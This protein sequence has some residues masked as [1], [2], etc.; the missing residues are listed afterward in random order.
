[1]YGILLATGTTL[2]K[3]TSTTVQYD[4]SISTCGAPLGKFLE[5]SWIDSEGIGMIH[6]GH[7]VTLTRPLEVNE[8]PWQAAEDARRHFLGSPT[9]VP[10]L[11]L[12]VSIILTNRKAVDGWSVLVWI[13]DKNVRKRPRL[14]KCIVEN[15]RFTSPL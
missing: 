11:E 8:W 5:D 10:I 12:K 6:D 15:A 7:S 9:D 3:T 14:V 1:M 2:G 4:R 13:V